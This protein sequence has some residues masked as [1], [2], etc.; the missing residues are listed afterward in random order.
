MSELQLSF[1]QFRANVFN[2]ILSSL[3]PNSRS[4]VH[5]AISY[6]QDPR[7]LI[8]PNIECSALIGALGTLVLPYEI[9]NRANLTLS[10]SMTLGRLNYAINAHDEIVELCNLKEEIEALALEAGLEY[11]S[12]KVTDGVR[13]ELSNDPSVLN[14]PAAINI[15]RQPQLEVAFQEFVRLQADR[16]I[17][18]LAEVLAKHGFRRPDIEGAYC[19]AIFKSMGHEANAKDIL[20]EDFEIINSDARDPLNIVYVLK[21]NEPTTSPLLLCRAMQER[22]R[23]RG[24]R[25]HLQPAWGFDAIHESLVPVVIERVVVETRTVEKEVPEMDWKSLIREPMLD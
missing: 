23:E 19:L 13:F 6:G 15:L 4:F 16:L 9:P 11:R 22:L 7:L 10:I 24:Y 20:K 3:T 25:V 14:A 1:A 18:G 5:A 12:R 8:L 21:S 2:D 17:L